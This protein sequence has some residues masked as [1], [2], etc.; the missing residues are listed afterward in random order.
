MCRFHNSGGL[1]RIYGDAL[2]DTRIL[3]HETNHN[4][5][6]LTDHSTCDVDVN[7]NHIPKPC[8]A[9][10]GNGVPGVVEQRQLDACHRDGSHGSS[11]PLNAVHGIV[12]T[13]VS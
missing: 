7:A 2:L 4:D 12:V 9:M 10:H 13:G 5:S 11:K 3:T 6:R 8:N 1:H